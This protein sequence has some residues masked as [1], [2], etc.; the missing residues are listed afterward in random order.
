[1]S[2]DLAN[3]VIGTADCSCVKNAFLVREKAFFDEKKQLK[4]F[5]KHENTRK[6]LQAIIRTVKKK[7]QAKRLYLNQF[8]ERKSLWTNLSKW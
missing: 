5:S 1:M 7:S 8:R 3:G 2:F 4:I 6:Q